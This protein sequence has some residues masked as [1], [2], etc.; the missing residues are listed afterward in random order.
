M[1][2]R[3]QQ[4][5]PSGATAT[6][7]APQTSRVMTW[8]RRWVFNP[9]SIALLLVLLLAVGLR[10]WWISYVDVDP[11]DGRLDDTLFYDRAA[12]ALAEGRGYVHLHGYPTAQWPP[13]YPF[14]LAGIY[15]AFGHTVFGA[16]ML[17]VFAGAATCLL[18]YALGAR[19]LNRKAGLL[20]A[21]I[22]A[23]FPSAVQFTALVAT[24]S[25]FPV[26]MLLLILLAISFGRQQNVSPL[27]LLA[28]GALAGLASL[29]RSEAPVLLA[30]IFIAWIA[31]RF[32]WRRFFGHG[33][34]MAVGAVAVIAPWTVRNALVMDAF[35]PISSGAG[36]TF[37]TGHREDPYD[38]LAIFPEAKLQ[39][40]YNYLPPPEREVKV[41]REAMKE[42]LEYMWGHPTEELQHLGEKF[43]QFYTDD[44]DA[45]RWINGKPEPLPLPPDEYNNWRIITDRYYYAVLALFVISIP[46]WISF[47]DYNR[48]LVVLVIVGWNAAHLIFFPGPRYHAPL[49][50]LFSLFAAYLLVLT[51]QGLFRLLR[52]VGRKPALALQRL[53]ERLRLTR[54]TEAAG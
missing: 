52:P 48:L 19:L 28:L 22:F 24:E 40:K 51:L 53:F 49:V 33:A 45:L 25:I 10:V 36:H 50:P 1:P 6:A 7:E 13:G 23:L 4:T 32:S 17:N 37:L 15:K 11:E 9:Y 42:G 16:K 2:A 30:M 43:R 26:I 29:V 14:I 39:E 47:R 8:L 27:K 5:S 38:P 41:E 35:I 44:S 3:Q 18:I 34:L 20:G 46:F 54:R 31:T 12:D 21:L